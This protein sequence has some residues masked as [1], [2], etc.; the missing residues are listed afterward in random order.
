MIILSL[1]YSILALSWN[2]LCG[3][4]GIFSLGHQAFFGI[5]AYVSA[6]L[7]MKAGVS[8]WFG[9]IIG[10]IVCTALS[11]IIGLP[12]LRLRSAPYIALTTLCFSEIAR[13]ICTNLV[14]LTR[15]DMGLWG[16]PHFSDIPLPL[17]GIITFK[18]TAS[19]SYYYLILIIFIITIMILYFSLKSHIG[20]AFRSIRDSREAAESLG[21]NITFYKLLAFMISTFFAGVAGGFYAHYLLILTPSSAFSVGMM[22]EVLT[23]TM[24][25]GIGTFMGP[26]VGAF[27]LTL[28]LEYLRFLGEYRLIIYGILIVAIVLFMPQGLMKKILPEE[29]T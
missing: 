1:V 17:I 21:I 2:F 29:E 27:S 5:G 12:C 15:G 11:F 3:Y 4:I 8:P 14:T 26:V 28:G 18:G 16:I 10:G 19:L 25:G 23:F 13:I 20:L 9:V 24:V 22:I 7:T 6:L